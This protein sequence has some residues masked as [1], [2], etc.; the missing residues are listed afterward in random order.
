MATTP[1][2]GTLPRLFSAPAVVAIL[3]AGLWLAGGKITDDFRLSMIL[4]AGWLAVAGAAALA[5]GWRWR[6]FAL[7]VIGTFVVAAVAIGG[8]LAW[9][10]LRDTVVN[11][12]VAVAGG[13]NV[14]RAA[15]EFT[16][17]AHETSGRAAVLDVAGGSRVLTL[18][19]FETDPGPD[20]R[21]YLVPRGADGV[22]GAEDLGG[23]K[24]NRGTQQYDVPADLGDEA[25]GAVVI[26]CRAFSVAFGRA[27]LEPA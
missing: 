23:L 14:E 1:V 17:L 4:A 22:D 12:T 19:D 5:I 3:L 6:S 8:L 24:G 26:W 15:G 16:G 2:I 9:T 10:T 25:L 7:P 11:E 13:G 21:V 27:A 20:L 18:T